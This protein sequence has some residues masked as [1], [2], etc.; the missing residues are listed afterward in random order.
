MNQRL[1]LAGEVLCT[2]GLAGVLDYD[3]AVTVGQFQNCIH[4]RHLTIQVN[5]DNRSYRP[6]TAE[7]NQSARS[8]AR[9][10]VLQIFVQG[11]GIHVV[12]AFVN[13]DKLRDSPGLRYCLRGRNECVGDGDDASVRAHSCRHECKPQSVGSAAHPNAMWNVAKAGE[14]AFEPVDHWSTNESGRS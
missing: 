14:V 8:I 3:Q 10:F 11:L 6:A 13:I 5:W 1:C 4:V 12:G 7:A 9:A 2:V